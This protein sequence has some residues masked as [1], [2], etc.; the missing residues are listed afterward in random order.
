MAEVT[1]WSR[2]RGPARQAVPVAVAEVRDLAAVRVVL[3][4]RV[5]LRYDWNLR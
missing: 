2:L 1:R 5:C 3:A 4:S